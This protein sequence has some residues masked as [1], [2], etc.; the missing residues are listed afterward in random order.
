MKRFALQTLSCLLVTALLLSASC[1]KSA[2]NG[3]DTTNT[4]S[5]VPKVNLTVTTFAGK[6]NDK[7]NAEDGAGSNARFWNPTKMVYD[8]RNNTL[9]VADGTTIRSV[10]A[11]ANVKTYLPLRSISNWDEILDIDLAPGAG[12]SLYFVSAEHNLWKVEPAGASI[13][14]TNLADR[15]YGGNETGALNSTDHFDGTHGMATGANGEIYFFNSFW[16]T[17]RRITLTSLSPVRGT[18][19]AFAGRPTASRSGNAWPFADGQGEAAAFGGS[20]PDIA[21]DAQ[22]N[23][24]VADYW[25]DELRMVTSGGSVTSLLRYRNGLGVDKDGPVATAEANRLTQVACTPDG[26]AVFFGTNGS[27]GNNLP[28][29]RMVKDKKEVITLTKSGVA[30]GD[31]S[32]DTAGIDTMGGIACTPD[33]KTVFVSEPGRKVIR[34]ITIQ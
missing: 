6:L 22:G 26:A 17:M 24:Y 33:G 11:A 8:Y 21:A 7:G 5:N 13:R 28:R 20:V 25:N 12:G 2:A 16:N 14:L 31:G 32:G 15:T 19:S 3:P 23:V 9:Y 18:V 29:L 27:G 1:S 30:Y 34:K 10:D 4:G